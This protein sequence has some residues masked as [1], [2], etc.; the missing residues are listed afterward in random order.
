[1]AAG[2]RGPAAIDRAGADEGGTF[3]PCLINSFTIPANGDLNPY[4]VAFV[5]ARFPRGGRVAAGDVLV[6]NFNDCR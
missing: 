6:S 3:I 2:A 4:G 5:P 1:M